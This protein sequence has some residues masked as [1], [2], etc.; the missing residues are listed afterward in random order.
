MNSAPMHLKS[1]T[2][3]NL[4][5]L[6]LYFFVVTSHV[7]GTFAVAPSNPMAFQTLADIY[8]FKGDIEKHLEVRIISC[9]Y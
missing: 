2:F 3:N 5:M 4:E 9:I 6:Y 1:G 8:D 7:M